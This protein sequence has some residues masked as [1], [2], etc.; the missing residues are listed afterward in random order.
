MGRCLP[1]QM[2]PKQSMTCQRQSKT[3]MLHWISWPCSWPTVNSLPARFTIFLNLHMRN[4]QV[5]GA[6]QNKLWWHVTFHSW[7]PVWPTHLSAATHMHHTEHC[8]MFLRHWQ[9]SVYHCSLTV[10]W[11]IIQTPRLAIISIYSNNINDD[12][13]IIMKPCFLWV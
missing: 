2:S 10:D 12:D 4:L 13:D 8:S 11:Q 1:K 6:M 7:Y 9:T 5:M 3:F